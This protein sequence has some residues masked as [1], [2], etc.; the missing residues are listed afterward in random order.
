M[1]R[2]GWSVILPWAAYNDNSL[3]AEDA[4]DAKENDRSDV[5]G[6]GSVEGCNPSPVLGNIFLWAPRSNVVIVFAESGFPWRPSRP[7]R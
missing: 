4:K 2:V 5:A 3:T 6:T 7:W 1:V